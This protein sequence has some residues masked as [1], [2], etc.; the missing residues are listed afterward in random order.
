MQWIGELGY[1]HQPLHTLENASRKLSW[2]VKRLLKKFLH[3][4]VISMNTN[5]WLSK[6]KFIRQK[7]YLR[8]L[9]VWQRNTQHFPL[10]PLREQQSKIPYYFIRINLYFMVTQERHYFFK[11]RM[12]RYDSQIH[13]KLMSM[14]AT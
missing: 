9:R 12:M 2:N 11:Y 10:S 4:I 5:E 8:T 1:V 13:M 6:I 3:K 14:L 7:Y